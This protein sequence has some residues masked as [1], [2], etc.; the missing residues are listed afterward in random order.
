MT[1]S[2]DIMDAEPLIACRMRVGDIRIAFDRYPAYKRQLQKASFAIE[3]VGLTVTSWERGS[4]WRMPL[5]VRQRRWE[6]GLD[7]ADER[8]WRIPADFDAQAY[9]R[10][11]WQG[12]I[13]KFLAIW[14]R[15]RRLT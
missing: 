9:Q 11:F 13:R 1:T 2:A 12:V 4:E 15:A 6:L 5:Y 3:I 14:R 10:S 8:D 7:Q